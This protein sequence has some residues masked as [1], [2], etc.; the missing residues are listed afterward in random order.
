M[1]RRFAG[2]HPH[3]IEQ[4]GRVSIPSDFRKV[5]RDLGSETLYLVPQLRKPTAH[6]CFSEL[7]Y[8][9]FCEQFESQD[10]SPEEQ[11]LFDEFVQARAKQLEPDDM[12]RIVIPAELRGTIGIEKEVVFVGLGS[13]FEL[14]APETHA[15]IAD[16]VVE[17]G[18]KLVAGI[19]MR[20]LV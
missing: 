19:R 3:K 17:K 15:S 4:R 9:R 18:Q 6:V 5:L 1:A 7:A 10:V 11:E 12:G 14:R 13:C 16:G 8:D 2:T 20:G